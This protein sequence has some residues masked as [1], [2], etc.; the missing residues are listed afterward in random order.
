MEST[1]LIESG[2][3]LNIRSLGDLAKI[4]YSPKD[5]KLHGNALQ[6]II[7]YFDEYKEFPKQS[8]LIEKFPALEVST[9]GYNFEY[10]LDE[11]GKQ[12]LFHRAYDA[13]KN[14]ENLLKNEPQKAIQKLI[15]SL[16]T[17]LVDYEDEISIYDAGSITRFDQYQ[18][19]KKER[20]T[21]KI[22]GIPTPFKTLNHTGVGW[23]KGELITV[24]ADTGVGKTWICLKTAAIALRHGFKVLFVSSEMPKAQVEMR[25]DVLLGSMMGYE[26]SH[27]ALRRGDPID[28]EKYKEFLAKANFKRLLACDSIDKNSITFPGIVSLVR[29]HKPDIVVLDAIYLVL[30]DNNGRNRATWE[31]MFN[32]FEQ[33]KPLCTSSDVAFFVSTQTN[34]KSND[35]L[36][37][38]RPPKLSDVA[39]GYSI[40]QSSDIVLTMC[41]VENEEKKRLVQ[42]QKLRD[43]EVEHEQMMMEWDVDKGVIREV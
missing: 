6:F 43:D 34:R 5:F 18:K 10:C 42:L 20:A 7:D 31:R 21:K 24:F 16:D 15:S 37:A 1:Q 14:N 9:V 19:R 3:V 33:L 25:L 8:L 22:I 30:P 38:F 4:R 27:K 23:Q 17:S 32:I 40:V 11:F 26:F 36:S 13:I 29:K 12:V 2:I 39:F 41:L 35:K 28:E